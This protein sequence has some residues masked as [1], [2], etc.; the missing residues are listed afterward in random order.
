MMGERFGVAR[1]NALLSVLRMQ[2]D[3]PV[4]GESAVRDVVDEGMVEAERAVHRMQIP[5]MRKAREAAGD[6]RR[7]VLRE[8]GRALNVERFADH[9]GALKELALRRFELV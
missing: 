1:L 4:H 6:D 2:P 3:P 7:I 8:Q 9:C 5:Q